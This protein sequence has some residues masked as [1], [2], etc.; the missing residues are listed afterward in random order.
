MRTYRIQNLFRIKHKYHVGEIDLI[1]M[2]LTEKLLNGEKIINYSIEILDE[3]EDLYVTDRLLISKT[4][5]YEEDYIGLMFKT[6]VDEEDSN[7]SFIIL[8]DIT[9]S[10]NRVL[11]FKIYFETL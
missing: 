9:T 1:K 11:K 4:D 10:L 2:C 5:N 3:Y 7:K 6:G 8:I